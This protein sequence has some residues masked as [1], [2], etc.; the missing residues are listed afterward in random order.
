M[1]LCVRARSLL[2]PKAMMR[3]RMNVAVRAG[4]NQRLSPETTDRETGDSD[5]QTGRGKDEWQLFRSHRRKTDGYTDRVDGQR[6]RRVPLVQKK[7][8]SSSVSS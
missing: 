6:H 8:L 5:R 1:C 4:N 2:A 7:L 3:I